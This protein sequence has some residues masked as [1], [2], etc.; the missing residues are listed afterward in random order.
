MDNTALKTFHNNSL[1]RESLKDFML[2]T[3]KE[4]AVEKAFAGESVVGIPE[5]K[6]LI[7][8]LFI[9]LDKLSSK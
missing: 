9:E 3:L 7:D 8:K 6:L 4:I 1:Q 2:E 5:A